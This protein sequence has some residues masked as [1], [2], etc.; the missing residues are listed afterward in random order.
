VQQ[1]ALSELSEIRLNTKPQ[2]VEV[3][4]TFE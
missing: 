3:V 4:E 1:K 2:K